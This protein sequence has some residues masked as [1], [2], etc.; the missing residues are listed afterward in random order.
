MSFKEDKFLA[1]VSNRSTDTIVVKAAP[2]IDSNSV[3]AAKE[4]GNTIARVLIPATPVKV[5]TSHVMT[6]TVSR[7]FFALRFVV[8]LPISDLKVKDYALLDD[9]IASSK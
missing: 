6:L 9:V 4:G 8:G 5:P 1:S 3:V 2:A 7:T